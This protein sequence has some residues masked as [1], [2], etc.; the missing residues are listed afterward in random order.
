MYS[1]IVVFTSV[2][3]ALNVLLTSRTAGTYIRL[4]EIHIVDD[5][6]S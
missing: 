5:Y 4:L 3:V 2:V 1:D 6:F